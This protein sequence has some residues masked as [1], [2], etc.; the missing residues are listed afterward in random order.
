[1]CEI[2]R[3]LG[4]A[5][6]EHEHPIGDLGDEAGSSGITGFQAQFK[7]HHQANMLALIGS[8]KWSETSLTYSFPDAA[9]DYTG[10]PSSYGSGELTAG[11]AQLALLCPTG[12][13]TGFPVQAATLET[14]KP[15]R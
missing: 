7:D 13:I 9:L 8:S 5:P 14:K 11:F 10:A 12:P 2:C 1:M 15:E 6:N 3:A 4:L